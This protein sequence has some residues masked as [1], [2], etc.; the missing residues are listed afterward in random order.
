MIRS[1]TMTSNGSD[2]EAERFC[3]VSSPL[4]WEA[5]RTASR[6]RSSNRLDLIEKT[7]LVDDRKPAFNCQYAYKQLGL[8]A[9]ADDV[10]KADLDAGSGS[11]RSSIDGLAGPSKRSKTG[12]LSLVSVMGMPSSGRSTQRA[13]KKQW[14]REAG[15]ATKSTEGGILKQEKSPQEATRGGEINAAPEDEQRQ[16]KRLRRAAER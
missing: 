7:H 10:L 4:Q 12:G 8:E 16:R 15:V 3:L 6:P 11:T 13:A 1:T 2:N 9:L 5:S 14:R